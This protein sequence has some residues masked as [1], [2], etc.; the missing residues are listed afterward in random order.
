[1]GT[2]GRRSIQEVMVVKGP[3]GAAINRPDPPRNLSAAEA[4]E[5]CAIV[6]S[7]PPGY[8]ARTQLVGLAQLC[9]LTVGLPELDRRIAACCKKKSSNREY[10]V[11]LG[12]RRKETMAIN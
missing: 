8:F 1:M 3:H 11:L 7:M 6:D 9:K 2:R 12:A 10:M 5:W 4:T